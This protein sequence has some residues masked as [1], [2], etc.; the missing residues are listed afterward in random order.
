MAGPH[1]RCC[2]VHILRVLLLLPASVTGVITNPGAGPP[3]ERLA[4]AF[5]Q[6]ETVEDRSAY[7]RALKEDGYACWLFPAVYEAAVC[8][9]VN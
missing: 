8:L 7:L 5:A 1:R 9:Q 4:I 3:G 6:D 2:V